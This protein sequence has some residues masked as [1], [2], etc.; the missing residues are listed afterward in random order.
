MES[1]SK[2]GK[3]YY[4]L[5]IETSCDDACA[6]IVSSNGDIVAEEHASNPESL[7]KY[8][9]IKPDEYYRFHMEHIDA[10]IQRV[11]EKAGV[12]MS[13]VK[14]VAVT[15]GPGM[16]ICL[17]VGHKAA[18]NVAEKYGIPVIGENHLAGHCLS[19]FIKGHQF[20]V[21]YGKKAQPSREL[22]YP[23]L[24][25]LLSG[26]HSQ[27]YVVESASRF[28]MLGDTM[29]HYAGNVLHKCA[30]E[31][32]LSVHNGGGP[33][34]EEAAKRVDGEPLF[35][36]TEPC[37]NMCFI[38]F[39]FSGIQTQ[40]R[41]LVHELREQYGEDIQRSHPDIVDHL[42]HTCQ[43][44]VSCNERLR[45][46]L[47][48]MLHKREKNE[49]ERRFAF[50]NRMYGYIKKSGLLRRFSRSDTRDNILIRNLVERM[51][52]VEDLSQFLRLLW[53]QDLYPDL[54]QRREGIHLSVQQKNALYCA[55][56]QA[57]LSLIN[58]SAFDNLRRNLHQQKRGASQPLQPDM[59]VMTELE[60]LEG[61]DGSELISK[62][63]KSK[64]N[65]NR[66]WELFTTSGKYCTDNAVMIAY[67]LLEKHRAGM[68]GLSDCIFKEPVT[69]K[70]NLS[71][72]RHW[73]LLSDISVLHSLT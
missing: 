52:N 57:Y 66:P 45:D 64:M 44:G 36:M 43:E 35:D 9:G 13:E 73:E 10:I 34:I 23:F 62:K 27:I 50:I 40:L 24:A 51:T 38:S 47:A 39:C 48:E 31:L 53:S 15:R 8:G 20:K 46:L 49:K 3:D 63:I 14:R 16:N 70:W 26:G 59:N 32:G 25:L 60:K 69:D 41:D 4:I 2:I 29:D 56:I 72:R 30:K 1:G 17:K 19:P 42:A 21:T 6:A 71:K 68:D 11:I 22:R 55:S 28:H 61:Q 33:S 54:L 7:V 37:K 12:N 18:V 58:D 5:A 65:E 67:S